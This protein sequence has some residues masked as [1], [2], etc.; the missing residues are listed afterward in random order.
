MQFSPPSMYVMRFR[1]NTLCFLLLILLASA[2]YAAA[3]PI[4]SLKTLVVKEEHDTARAKLL[5]A[6]GTA[7][8]NTNLDSA[9]RYWELALDL[10]E[11]LSKN[12][13]M[14][15]RKAGKL[16]VMRSSSNTAV[17]FQ[18]RGLYPLALRQYQRCLRI[19]EELGDQRGRMIALNNIGLIKLSQ[20]KHAEALEYFERSHKLALQLKDS[21]V[22]STTIN[23]VGTALKR[24]E[25]YEEALTKFRESLVWAERMENDIQIVDDLINIGSIQSHN[26]E[27]DSSL[28]TFE[29]CLVMANAIEYDLAKPTILSGLSASYLGLKRLPEALHYAEASLDSARSLDLTEEIVNA[30]DQLAEVQ[31]H[32]GMFESADKT[33]HE[34]IELKDSLFSTSKALEFGQLEESFGYERKEYEQAIQNNKATEAKRA[35]NRRQY[36]IASAWFLG[37][38]VILLIGVRYARSRRVR[39]M[40]VF[41]SLLFFFEFLLVLLDSYVDR[42]TGGLPIPK[43]AVNVGIALII[44]PLNT[45]L[46]RWLVH[47]ERGRIVE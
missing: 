45:I 11:I 1:G 32:L 37:V 46:E 27:F 17:V 28:V 16:Q 13:D 47:R 4:D 29:R 41:I 23:N 39:F 12:E 25:R 14:A 6:L 33:L 7:Y 26:K 19:A 34:Y 24:L 43:L 18:Y 15:I 9:L 2:G 8:F 22:G 36:L 38:V 20:E 40:V 31:E 44:A 5:N 21:T 30:L 3:N 35:E 42:I 10:G